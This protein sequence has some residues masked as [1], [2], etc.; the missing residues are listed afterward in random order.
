MCDILSDVSQ[1]LEHSS[2]RT[3]ADAKQE[4][5]FLESSETSLHKRTV[6]LKTE[7]EKADLARLLSNKLLNKQK[8]W[9]M[10]VYAHQLYSG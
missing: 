6:N 3:P 8:D 4:V 5:N 10:F 2:S 1:F 9:F 7:D